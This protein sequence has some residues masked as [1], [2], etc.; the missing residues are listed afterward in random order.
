[1]IR[2]LPPHRNSWTNPA[3]KAAGKLWRW[4]AQSFSWRPAPMRQAFVMEI[5]RNRMVL[6]PVPL[7][8]RRAVIRRTQL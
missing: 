8:E 3:S 7:Y 4:I 2:R 6:H 5:C 1:M